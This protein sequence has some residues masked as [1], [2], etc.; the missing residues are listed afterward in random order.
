MRRPRYPFSYD[1]CCRPSTIAVNRPF[2]CTE[3]G[4]NKLFSRN[5]ILRNHVD[6]EHKKL[7][8][9]CFLCGFQFRYQN[10]LTKHRN[11]THLGR[12]RFVCAQESQT[13]VPLEG[14]ACGRSF[15]TRLELTRHKR[16]FPRRDARL[17]ELLF[18]TRPLRLVQKLQTSTSSV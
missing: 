9:P 1:G 7:V 3:P 18:G 13:D 6:A 14:C 15:G 11:V 12:R 8:Y 16:S 10:D 4:C 5:T 17:L 2:A